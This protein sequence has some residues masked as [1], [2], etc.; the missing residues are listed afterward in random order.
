MFDQ[1]KN[2][3]REGDL[4]S[5][6]FTKDRN[7]YSIPYVFKTY[8]GALHEPSKLSHYFKEIFIN[9][10]TNKDISCS[11]SGIKFMCEFEELMGDILVQYANEA[12]W[13]GQGNKQ[14]DIMQDYLIWNDHQT[15]AIEVPVYNYEANISGHI[16]IVRIVNG[17]VQIVDF[18]PKAKKEKPDKVG[19]QLSLYRMLLSHNTGI[20]EKNID[21]F[22][23]DDFNMYKLV[24]SVADVDTLTKDARFDEKLK[25]AVS[26]F[27]PF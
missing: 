19:A 10:Y 1:L 7:G 23:Y 21:C 27:L 9:G 6:R 11:N 2:N 3:Y 15:I 8:S 18:K 26:L 4:I 24:S 5:R 16:D 25:S 20:D 14:H 13:Q 12:E 17:R 22:Y